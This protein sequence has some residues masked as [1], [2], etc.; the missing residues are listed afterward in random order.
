MKTSYH[1]HHPFLL[2]VLLLSF[3]PAPNARR[4]SNGAYDHL[5]LVY[6]W[7]NTFCLNKTAA[8]KTPVPQNFI[9]HGLWPADRTGKTLVYCDKPENISWA[10]SLLLS[11]II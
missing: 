8:C 9:L 10:V 3:S 11:L 1:H 6:T 2:L 5:E 4:R 7:P